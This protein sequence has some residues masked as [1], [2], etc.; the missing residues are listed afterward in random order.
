MDLA[1]VI[2]VFNE[3]TSIQSLINDLYNLTVAEKISCRF[4]II[5]DGS[6]D[7]SLAIL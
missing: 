5:N 3:E 1:I 4:I 6:T 7:G 2:P